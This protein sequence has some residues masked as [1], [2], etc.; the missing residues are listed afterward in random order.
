MYKVMVVDDEQIVLDAMSYIIKKRNDQVTVCET[1]TSGREAIEKA[2]TSHPDIIF[3]DIRMPGL[4]GIDAITEIKLTLPTTKFVIVSAYEQ[5]DYAKQA[6]QLAVTDYISKPINRQKVNDI[7]DTLIK[8]IDSERTKKKREIDNIHK[9]NR[10]LPFMESSFINTLIMPRNNSDEILDQLSLLDIQVG[11]G[12]FLTMD[13]TLAHNPFNEGPIEPRGVLLSQNDYQNIRHYIKEITPALVGPMMTNRMLFFMAFDPIK[14]QY[15]IRLETMDI[16]EKIEK[17]VSKMGYRC[18]LG[19]GNCHSIQDGSFSFQE[20]LKALLRSGSEGICHVADLYHDNCHYLE[21]TKLKMQLLQSV[22]AGKTDLALFYFDRLY[23][24]IIDRN[25]KIMELVVLLYHGAS[26]AEIP[27]DSLLNYNDY[28]KDAVAINQTEILNQWIVT[29]IRHIAGKMGTLRETSYSYIVDRCRAEIKANYA[30]DLT[31]EGVARTI[32]ISPQYL[33]KLFKDQ[34]GVTFIDYL[35]DL[36]L[37]EAKRLMS[38]GTLS[39]KEI[40]FMVGYTDPNYFSRVFKKHIGLNPT[41]YAR[42]LNGFSHDIEER[43]AIHV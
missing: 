24:I 36:R 21:E 4:S 25:E 16:A 14:S 41:E 3:I 39:I 27:E 13:L 20:S 10:M 31:L 40:C 23:P 34:I 12:C 28:L 37:I 33:S 35:T 17:F 2:I 26:E 15:D 5:F 18:G 43:E 30:T 11:Y 19:I 38:Q 6:V 7:L 1:A 29:R 9:L 42:G 22:T 8:T 32:N